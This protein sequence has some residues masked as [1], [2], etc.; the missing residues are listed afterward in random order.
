MK[1]LPIADCRLSIEGAVLPAPL[2]ASGVIELRHQSEI[3]NRKLEIPSLLRR[4]ARGSHH[5][6]Q[7]VGF[8]EQRG[9]LVGRHRV[10]LSE[11]FEPEHRLVGFLFYDTHLGDELRPTAR[12][13]RRP[14]ICRHRRSAAHQL[15]TK[16]PPHRGGRQ[17]LDQL[18]D[19]KRKCLRPLLQFDW[20]HAPKL[21]GPSPASQ[22]AIGNRQSAIP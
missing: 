21:T 12:A 9:E 10:R 17:R 13:T 3:G 18:D 1:R 19:T 5:G 7:L 6:R 8:A 2:A 14:I 20:S 4:L 11:K 15:P 16:R 22:S